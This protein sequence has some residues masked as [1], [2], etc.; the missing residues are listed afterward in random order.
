MLGTTTAVDGLSEVPGL[1]LPHVGERAEPVW[2]QFVIRY[3]NRDALQ[4]HLT[5]AG[6]GS[7]IHYPIPPHLS[8]AYSDMRYKQGDFPVTETIANTV[9][10]LPMGLH[11]KVEEVHSVVE[12]IATFTSVSAKG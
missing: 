1:V 10:S 3:A 9:L 5:E 11:M 8:G 6:I 12:A 2:Y 7:L 4:K